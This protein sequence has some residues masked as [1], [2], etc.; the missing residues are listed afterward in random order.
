ML[1]AASRDSLA[2]LVT[3]TPLL[4][5]APPDGLSTSHVRA[6]LRSASGRHTATAAITD[7]E[8]A[9]R[10]MATRSTMFE[11]ASLKRVKNSSFGG[12]IPWPTGDLPGPT[13]PACAPPDFAELLAG[14]GVPLVPIG[15]PVRPPANGPR[16]RFTA[17]RPPHAAELVAA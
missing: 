14:V 7:P 11:P 2:E 3:G 15:Q 12:C 8:R 13:V 9:A 5:D 17:D 6:F 16:R 4:H 10:G 1:A